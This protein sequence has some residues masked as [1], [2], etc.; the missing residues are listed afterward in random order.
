[1]YTSQA[2][3]TSTNAD[4]VQFDLLRA[5]SYEQ[6]L[7]LMTDLTLAVQ[8]L[9]FGGLRARHPDATDDEIWLRLAARRLGADRVR[10]VYGWSADDE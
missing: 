1:M 2:P 9:A 6:R 5:M 3:D 7:A 10:T 4:R 8:R